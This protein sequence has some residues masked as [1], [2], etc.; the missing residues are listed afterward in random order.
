MIHAIPDSTCGRIDEIG[1]EKF[2][3]GFEDAH[4]YVAGTQA[5]EQGRG[6]R[7]DAVGRVAG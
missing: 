7:G 6:R 5:R 2:V 3:F 1:L 4:G